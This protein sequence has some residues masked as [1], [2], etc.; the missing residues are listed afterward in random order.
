MKTKARTEI[1]TV[2][3]GDSFGRS[4]H[5]GWVF[6]GDR[7]ADAAEDI[8]KAGFHRRHEISGT[9]M[10]L[11]G[12]PKEAAGEKGKAGGHGVNSTA[13]KLKQD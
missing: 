2:L 3:G 10:A 8:G 11:I 6:R 13:W 4:F 9:K 1:D 5:I 7:I 12:K